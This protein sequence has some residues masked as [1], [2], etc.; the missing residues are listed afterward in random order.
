MI[1]TGSGMTRDGLA[2][3]V[4]PGGPPSATNAADGAGERPR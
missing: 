1:A 4:N 3:A 2:G